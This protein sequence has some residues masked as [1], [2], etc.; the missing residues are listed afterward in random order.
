M[1]NEAEIISNPTSVPTAVSESY[2]RQNTRAYAATNGIDHTYMALTGELQATL[3]QSGPV[4]VNGTL[5]SINSQVNFT[6]PNTG[7]YYVHLV[8]TGN[9]L[10]PT[11]STDAG[12]W[13]ASKN[14]RYNSSGER[15]LNWVI[16]RG[17]ITTALGSYVDRLM[18]PALG[19]NSFAG[20]DMPQKWTMTGTAAW[21]APRSKYYDIEIQAAGGKGVNYSDPTF[22]GGGGGGGGYGRFRIFIAEGTTCTITMTITSGGSC[23]FNDGTNILYSTNGS[24]ASGYNG[25]AGGGGGVGSGLYFLAIGQSGDNGVNFDTGSGLTFKGGSG[26]CSFLGF[27]GH[28]QIYRSTTVQKSATS[29]FNYGGGGGGCINSSTPGS[30]SGGVIIITG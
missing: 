23:S 1:A 10:T 18:E 27:S 24:D 5:Y 2:A 16:S 21:V 9:N 28:G 14:A 17:G 25:G 8:G 6:I 13:V 12:S 29:G 19:R 15:V 22:C 30:G 20:A 26:G 3:Y 7:Q 4:D 11:L